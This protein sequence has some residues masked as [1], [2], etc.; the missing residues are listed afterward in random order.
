M[1]D[2]F[3]IPLLQSERV[4]SDGNFFFFFRFS[5]M[6]FNIYSTNIGNPSKISIRKDTKGLISTDWFLEKVSGK[7]FRIYPL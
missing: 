3:K 5:T 2:I 7:S 1:K 4:V 6:P